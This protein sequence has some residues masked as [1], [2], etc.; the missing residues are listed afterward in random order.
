MCVHV[1][2]HVYIC[3]YIHACVHTCTVRTFNF[4]KIILRLVF[5]QIL[6]FVFPR[7]CW[8][9]ACSLWVLQHDSC[10]MNRSFKA[11]FCSLLLDALGS[12]NIKINTLHALLTVGDGVS[13]N[14]NDASY[15]SH[16]KQS[17]FLYYV[18]YYTS[19]ELTEGSSHRYCTFT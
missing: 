16:L 1:V 5:L 7:S 9:V 12:K 8:V 4:F 11:Y 17:L 2:S 10:C 14:L 18:I 15:I 13:N 19:C 3:V 6:R